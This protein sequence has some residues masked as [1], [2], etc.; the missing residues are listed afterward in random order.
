MKFYKDF[1]LKEFVAETYFLKNLPDGK[2]YFYDWAKYCVFIKNGKK[3]GIEEKY[4]NS[5]GNIELIT[6]YENGRK[7]G[8]EISYNTNGTKTVEKYYE[9]GFKLYEIHFQRKK[10]KTLEQI[11]QLERVLKEL[12]ESVGETGCKDLGF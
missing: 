8:F 6:N 7:Q 3:H 11:K 4:Y 9:N 5:N 2:Y 10:E 1:D 12:K